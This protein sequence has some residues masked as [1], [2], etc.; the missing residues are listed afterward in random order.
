MLTIINYQQKQN[1]SSHMKIKVEIKH[2]YGRPLV[3]P[4]CNVAKCFARIAQTDTLT[5]TVT[6]EIKNIG[7]KIE[8]KQQSIE[9]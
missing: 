8:I 7:Y 1:E 4:V 6:N 2:V 5:P 3:Y 9:I